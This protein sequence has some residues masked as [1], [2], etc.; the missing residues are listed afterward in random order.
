MRQAAEVWAWQGLEVLARASVEP[1]VIHMVVSFDDESI[2]TYVE[3]FD[4]V[5]AFL[6]NRPGDDDRPP[7]LSDAR[8]DQVAIR[9]R[10]GSGTGEG[11]YLDLHLTFY[12]NNYFESGIALHLRFWD[13]N[14]V[15]IALAGELHV[16]LCDMTVEDL[17]EDTRE[18]QAAGL[19]RLRVKLDFNWPGTYEF[20]LTCALISVI[21]IGEMKISDLN[22]F[23]PG[24][25]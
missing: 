15:S 10:R 1:E 23:K 22:R 24:T 14:D 2:S 7:G 13:L 11:P 16:D 12:R 25:S 6:A 18:L 3:G 4:R 5:L 8:I 21:S 20:A 17:L 9:K 19:R